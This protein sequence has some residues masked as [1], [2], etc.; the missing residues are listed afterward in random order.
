MRI[1][2]A[3]A[4]GIVLILTGCAGRPAGAPP[5]WIHES[6]GRADRGERIIA[7][8]SG[9]NTA[10]AERILYRD[11]ESQVTRVLTEGAI[12]RGLTLDDATG[13]AIEEASRSRST[14]LQGDRFL[15]SD[16]GNR[17]E[18]FLL[19]LY[20]TEMIEEDLDA[21]QRAVNAAARSVG[22]R[23]GTN[24]ILWTELV[25]ALA[26]PPPD[27]YDERLRRLDGAASRAES[28]ELAIDLSVPSMALADAAS[29][30]L[31]VQFRI[32][33]RSEARAIPLRTDLRI[34]ETAPLYDGERREREDELEI[35]EGTETFWSSLP[36][37]IS[38]TWLYQAEPVWLEAAL[39]RWNLAI[40]E[41][42]ERRRSSL[43]ALIGRIEDR[44]RV[45]ATMTVTSAAPSI[46]TAVIIL[47]RDIAGNPISGDTAARNAVRRFDDLGYR[48]RLVEL[49]DEARRRLSSRRSL[50]VEELYDILPFEVLS[51]VDRAVIGWADIRAFDEGESISVEVG[52]EIEVYDLRR[53]RVL[54]RVTLE[55]RTAGGDA[56]SA[57][58]AAFSSAG[59]RAADLLAPRLP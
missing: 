26:D 31:T 55:E 21:I 4:I 12:A 59:R 33:A 35:E 27:T 58:R 44:L 18:L 17:S 15:R 52:A 45:R 34:R 9:I 20:S 13:A 28:I 49:G 57:I 54:T 19:V 50:D 16:G 41:E 8:G 14:D 39:E 22:P 42:S 23:R 36:P 32:D 46:P 47:D 2:E 10:E 11:L 37:D 30:G 43:L 25:L 56:P 1:R 38:G 3:V 53:D 29:P 6:S 40:L 48:V 7:Y 5:E 24:E 51:I